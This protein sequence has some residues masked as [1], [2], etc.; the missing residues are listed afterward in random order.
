MN[1]EDMTA[2]LN[3]MLATHVFDKESGHWIEE[4]RER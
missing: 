1:W 3:V 2:H 4:V